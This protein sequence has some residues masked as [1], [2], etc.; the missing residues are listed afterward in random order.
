MKVIKKTKAQY[1][2]VKQFKIATPLIS[3]I[4]FA[5]IILFVL[6][7]FVDWRMVVFLVVVIFINISMEKVRLRANLPA[8]FELSTFST[9]LVTIAFGIQWGIVTAVFSKLITSIATG[10]L[11]ADHFFMIATYINAALWASLF[12]GVSIFGLGMGIVTLNCIIM[13]MLSKNLL[14]LDPTSNLSFTGTNFIFNLIVFS[15]FSEIVKGL[16]I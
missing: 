4:T 14:G 8:D 2:K 9:V 11:L 7:R 5:A 3:R 12:A 16:L 6:S 1:G 10:N 15:I 13:F